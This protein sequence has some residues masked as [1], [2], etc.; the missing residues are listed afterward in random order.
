MKIKI[1]LL[2]VLFYILPAQA[3]EKQIIT[4]DHVKLYVNVKGQGTPCLYIHGGP[5]SGSYWMEKFFGD[6]LEQHFRMIYLDQRGVGRSSTPEDHNYSMERMLKDFEEVRKA[7][8]IENWLTLGH[9]FG[10]ILQAEYARNFPQSTKGL[11]MINCTLDMRE[12][13]CTSWIPK[14][15][16]FLGIEDTVEC[17]ENPAQLLNGFMGVAGPLNEQGLA[18]KMAFALQEN[19]NRMDATYEE[20]PGWNNDFSSVALTIGDYW[21]N[22][23]TITPEIDQPV[24]FFYG[25]KDWSVGPEH[26]KSINF[27]N[28]ILYGSDVGHIPFMENRADLGKAITTYMKKYLL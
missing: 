21:K 14:A 26:Y 24:L 22:F 19:E 23:K 12:S 11:I 9:S 7:L 25:Y 6:F 4:S 3:Q 10:G 28:M 5:G 17:S 13:F 18:W 15:C 2:V 16:E 1:L 20:I 27:P 8:G